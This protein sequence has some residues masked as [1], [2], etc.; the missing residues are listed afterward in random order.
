MDCHSCRH[1]TYSGCRYGRC[2]HPGHCDV[3]LKRGEPDGK[4]PYDRRICPDFELRMRCANCRYWIRGKYSSDGKTP[5]RKGSCS[6][7]L[8]SGVDGECVM[9]RK[10]IPMRQPGSN[11]KKGGQR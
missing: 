9:W 7:G 1:I 8:R 10:G 6:I 2:S 5:A 11:A 3:M 4:R